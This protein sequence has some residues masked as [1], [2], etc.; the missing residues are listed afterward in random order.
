MMLPMFDDM[1][2][3]TY[4]LSEIQINWAYRR[5]RQGLSRERQANLLVRQKG[6]CKLSGVEL[7]F[8]LEDGTPQARGLGCHPLYPAV[9]HIVPGNP[10]G[11]HQIIC[12]ALN[13]LKGHMPP[14][15]FNALKRTNAWLGLM[16]SWVA[17]AQRNPHDRNA[18]K[19]LIRP[20]VG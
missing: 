16:K 1:M 9:D 3:Q 7:T 6:V 19:Q 12:Y 10:D 11:G 5:H 20:N 4:Q 15:C 13:D 2:Q 8:N 14:D 18:F 17:Q